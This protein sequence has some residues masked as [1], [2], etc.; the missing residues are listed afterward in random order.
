MAAEQS[1]EAK[2][3]SLV[4]KVEMRIAL[5]DGDQKLQATLNTYLAPLLLKLASEHMSV[6][7][8]VCT[9]TAR[10]ALFLAIR[11]VCGIRTLSDACSPGHQHLS[12]RQS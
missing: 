7:N 4:G 10:E 8:K 6:R 11:I 9:Y 1:P 3:L 12:T 5:A 2:E